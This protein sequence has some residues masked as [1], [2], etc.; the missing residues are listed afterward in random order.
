MNKFGPNALGDPDETEIALRNDV[1][2]EIQDLAQ[3]MVSDPGALKALKRA[4]LTGDFLPEDEEMVFGRTGVAAKYPKGLIFAGPDA[5]RRAVTQAL[6]RRVVAGVFETPY[7][8]A[9]RSY[10]FER[11]YVFGG[12][13]NHDYS[14]R[15]K[16]ME[17]TFD[18][19][20]AVL[21]EYARYDQIPVIIAKLRGHTFEN[22]GAPEDEEADILFPLHEHARKIFRKHGLIG[23]RLSTGGILEPLKRLNVSIDDKK[24]VRLATSKFGLGFI[25]EFTE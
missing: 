5:D 11:T 6:A 1:T 20:Y 16:Q 23:S 3:K 9:A 25:K 19:F 7:T 21:V 8:E 4:G 2:L 15:I 10:V 12:K 14:K 13:I 24:A 17:I 22:P 18:E